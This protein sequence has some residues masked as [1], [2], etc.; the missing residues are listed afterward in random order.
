[1]QK[2]DVVVVGAGPAGSVAAQQLAREGFSV[3][4]LEK[5]RLPRYK[6][7][8][9]GVSAK[10]A[11]LL[12]GGWEHLAEDI[13][14]KVVFTHRYHSPVTVE[15]DEPLIYM[16]MRERFDSFL[17]SQAR[18]AGVEV[19]EE[20]GVST[21]TEE[22]G[23]VTV[24]AGDKVFHARAL[25]GADGASSKVARALGLSAHRRL[26]MAVEG[27]VSVSSEQMNQYRGTVV[28]NHGCVPH[29]YDWIFPKGEHLSIGTGS[30]SPKARGLKNFLNQFH[31]QFGISTV[32]RWSLKGHPIPTLSDR[33][34]S[35]HTNRCLLV[36]D[37]AGLVDPFSGEGIHHAVKSARL[38]AEVIASGLRQNLDCSRYTH[39]VHQEILPEL[40]H[41]GRVARVVFTFPSLMHRLVQANPE[42]L[43]RLMQVVF[44]SSTYH[45]LYR[46]LADRH[47]IFRIFS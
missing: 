27:E 40:A 20:A 16:V 36:G 10:T 19:L 33:N 41:A 1:M 23:Q 9:G 35:F 15:Y 37:A 14:R 34:Q 2:F 25:V 42:I 5:R 43:R 22:P 12:D 17:V 4:L 3:L 39:M 38:A 44:G 29:G 13:T 28:L 45:D 46:Y 26:S 7:C 24:Q 21:V 32:S 6:P 31:H 8:G 11:R 30:F 47:F 18:D